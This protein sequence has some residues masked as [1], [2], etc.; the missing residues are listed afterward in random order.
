MSNGKKRRLETEKEELNKRALELLSSPDLLPRYLDVTARI[1]LVGEERNALAVFTTGV[2]RLLKKPINLIVKGPSSTGK[3][4]LV[5]SCLHTFPQDAIRILTSSSATAWS[6]AA[7]D[8]VHRIVYLQERNEASGAVHPLRLL[9]SEGQLIRIVTVW[10]EGRRIQKRYVT[11]GPIASISTTTRNQLEIDDETRNI[12]LWIDESKRQ[13]RRITLA[14]ARNP[15][16]P[17][18]QE[19]AVWRQAQRILQNRIGTTI[20]LPE[21]F[22]H[23]AGLVYAGDVRV[24]RYF[25]AFTTVCKTMALLRSF[26]RYPELDLKKNGYI[27]VSFEDYAIAWVIFEP[28]FVESLHRGDDEALTTRAAVEKIAK[29]NHGRGVN[30]VQLASELS[31]SND[32]AHQRLRHAT[33]REAVRRANAPE[34][35]NRKLF[36]PNRMPSFLPDPDK[37]F[38]EIPEVGDWFRFIHPLTGEWISLR[39]K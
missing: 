15:D 4:H 17:S 18:R 19:I 8:F 13:T 12:S 26:Q 1:G 9:I 36:L 37:V 20:R 2:S 28:I 3:N 10:A 6:Y 16:R 38:T 21:W 30:A 22:E 34:K 27:E 39:R 31:I 33:E 14:N 29:R 7:D 23:I 5:N 35:G 11:K 25:P 24:R 32:K